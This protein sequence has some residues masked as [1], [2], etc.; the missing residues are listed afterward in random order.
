M[1]A[2]P[3]VSWLLVPKHS[4]RPN[5][6]KLP[7]M[8]FN[9][10]AEVAFKKVVKGGFIHV[11]PVMLYDMVTC[12]PH[13]RIRSLSLSPVKSPFLLVKSQFLSGKKKSSSGE[14]RIL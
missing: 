4:S 8:V 11:L 13:F 14:A 7:A 3:Q 5:H 1:T 9:F 10:L 6:P 2:A 12:F